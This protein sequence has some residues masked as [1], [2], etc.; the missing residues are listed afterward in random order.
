M[1]TARVISKKMKFLFHVIVFFI[2]V[3]FL[4]LA[5][6]S[7]T[8]Y[9]SVYLYKYIK[10]NQKGWKG[11]IHTTDVELGYAPVPNSRGAHVFPIGPDIPTCFDKDG[12][13]AP[14]EPGTVSNPKPLIL[15]LGCSFTYGDGV[16]AEETYPYLVA[17]S[18]NGTV[19]NAG[20]CSY[21]L[22][23][24]LV[25]AKRLVPLYKPDY[26]LV[27]YSTWLV[28]RA[29]APFAPTDYGKLP[30]PFFYEKDHKLVL[31]PPVFLSKVFDL[32]FDSYRNS[33]SGWM[34]ALSFFWKVGLPLAFH[35]DTNM[36]KY[37]LHK[38]IGT[39]P[40]ATASRDLLIRSVYEEID[41]V[42]KENSSKMVVV[43]LGNNWKAVDIETRLLPSDAIL[44]NAHNA[45]LDH[46]F[47][48]DYASYIMDYSIWRGDPPIVVDNHPNQLAHKI[49]AETIVSEINKTAIVANPE[50]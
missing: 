24:M 21:G 1:E 34:D 19:K 30:V 7:Y 48:S 2:P 31:Y 46:L 38:V 44:V 13:R 28:D 27:Q 26:L 40:K 47:V 41:K 5:Y 45:L 29:Q 25:L 23:Q 20:V 49:I 36:L 15:V 33:P 17:Q 14:F 32:P 9:K 12:F 50:N 37:M 43:I 42:A 3:A 10:T 18:M 4:G 35:D 22:S 11:R 16:S 39:I 8:A 6:T